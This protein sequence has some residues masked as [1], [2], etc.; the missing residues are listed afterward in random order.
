M[1]ACPT[2]YRAK[3]VKCEKANAMRGPK[4]SLGSGS[5]KPS[6]DGKKGSEESRRGLFQKWQV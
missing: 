6:A 2:P 5:K 4:Y 1:N 3:S